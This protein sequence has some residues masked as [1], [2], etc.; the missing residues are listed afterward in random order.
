MPALGYHN[1]TRNLKLSAI[2]WPRVGD[3]KFIF[4]K[5][6][7]KKTEEKIDSLIPT[8]K[9]EEE[10]NNGTATEEKKSVKI[11]INYIERVKEEA[12][13]IGMEVKNDNEIIKTLLSVTFD[14]YRKN[15][16]DN[17]YFQKIFVSANATLKSEVAK[18]L[19]AIQNEIK[20]QEMYMDYLLGRIS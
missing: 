15:K 20:N 3:N 11:I 16:I 10:A 9:T 4:M 6:K 14:N 17:E 5:I 7:K 12:A 1:G 19:S 8:I 13:K 18:T 2:E